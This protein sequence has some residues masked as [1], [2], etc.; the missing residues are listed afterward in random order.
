[1]K[2]STRGFSLVELLVASFVL[3]VSITAFFSLRSQE[4]RSAQCLS[5]RAHAFALARNHVRL[6]EAMSD[7][8]CL[9]DSAFEKGDGSYVLPANKVLGHDLALGK[10]LAEWMKE[11][12]ANVL[13]CWFPGQVEPHMGTLTCTV[14]YQPKNIKM[15]PKTI[16]LPMVLPL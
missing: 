1:M 12:E 5:D 6:I 7:K 2:R 11:R 3:A 16:E 13:I 15:S 8:S 4:L 9:E 10:S 14:R